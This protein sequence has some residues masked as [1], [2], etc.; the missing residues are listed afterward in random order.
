MF[1]TRQ[2]SSFLALPLAVAALAAPGALN[3]QSSDENP[4]TT[5]L[6]FG[7]SIGVLTPLAKLADSGDTI[8]AEFS[9]KMSFGAELDYW[10]GAGFGIGIVGGYSRPELTLQVVEDVGAFPTAIDLGSVDLWTAGANI[11]WRPELSGSAATVRPYFGGGVALVSVTYPTGGPLEVEDE[12][13]LAG[14]ILGGAHVV[15]TGGW[16][17]RLDVRDYI[18]TFDTA[19]FDETKTQHDLITSVVVGY[20]F[21]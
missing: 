12:S 19:P 2:I 15:I 13:R 9:T 6:E 4:P 20:A 3:A 17:A 10:F 16:F 11:M 5:G 8:R 14:T 18:S 1:R 21:H 7:A